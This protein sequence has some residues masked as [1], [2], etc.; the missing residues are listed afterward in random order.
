MK[1][2]SFPTG[3]TEVWRSRG[4]GGR[5]VK[6]QG[7]G[8]DTDQQCAPNCF[9]RLLVAVTDVQGGHLGPGS[10]AGPGVL[11]LRLFTGLPSVSPKQ[12]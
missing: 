8:E 6:A 12:P 11:S 5:Q 4:V 1:T 9:L 10:L 3:N 2:S 7:P